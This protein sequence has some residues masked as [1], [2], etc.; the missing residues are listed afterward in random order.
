LLLIG[1]AMA[2]T[3]AMLDSAWVLV[4]YLCLWVLTGVLALL[5]FLVLLKRLRRRYPEEG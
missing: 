3:A 2:I 5:L 4:A 1:I